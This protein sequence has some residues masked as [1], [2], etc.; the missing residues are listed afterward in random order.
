MKKLL[1]FALLAAELFVG[2]LL[3]IALCASLYI[4]AILAVAATLAMLTWQIILLAKRP[5]PARIRRIKR[6][7]ALVLLIPIATF[8]VTYVCVAI[9]MV[10]AFA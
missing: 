4:P 6:N 3:M 9:A 10:I 5:D 2:V 8:A 1:Y 7:I